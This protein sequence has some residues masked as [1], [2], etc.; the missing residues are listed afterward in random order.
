DETYMPREVA[1]RLRETGEW[2]GEGD[3]PAPS[4]AAPSNAAYVT[5]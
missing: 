1:D 5:E 3:A 4:G 2:R